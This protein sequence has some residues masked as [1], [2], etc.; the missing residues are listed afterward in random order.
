MRVKYQTRTVTKT[1]STNG[2]TIP[3]NAAFIQDIA[4]ALIDMGAP[5]DADTYIDLGGEPCISFVGEGKNVGS[6]AAGILM[7]YYQQEENNS[8]VFDVILYG[9]NELTFAN[10]I[11]VATINYGFTNNKNA[12]VTIHAVKSGDSFFFGIIPAT[13][14]PNGGCI[15]FAITPMK[16]LSDPSVNLG[17]AIVE[18]AATTG[19]DQLVGGS[20]SKTLPF[21]EGFNYMNGMF[22]FTGAGYKAAFPESDTGK[23][24]LVPYFAGIEDIYYDKVYVSPLG[25]GSTEEKAIETD[26]GTFLIAGQHGTDF[27]QVL[28]N[29]F[30]FDI[31]EAVNTAQ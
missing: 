6:G 28:H 19:P 27:T 29:T 16:R 9:R 1:F 12:I 25:R 4:N 23:I 14:D 8:L 2:G 7:P 17:Y 30:A 21:V 22:N 3:E 31:T 18:G 26:K 24:P 11:Y 20:F 15:S 5:L 13:G 10:S